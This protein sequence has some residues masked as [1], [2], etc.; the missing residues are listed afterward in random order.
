VQT[1]VG[2]GTIT[3]CRIQ[4]TDTEYSSQDYLLEELCIAIDKRKMLSL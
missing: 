2:A 4:N 1:K 3:E